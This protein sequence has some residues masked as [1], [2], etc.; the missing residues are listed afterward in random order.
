MIITPEFPQINIGQTDSLW[1][2]R[3]TSGPGPIADIDMTAT[4]LDSRVTYTGPPH[5]YF[6]Q[7]GQLFQSALNQYPLE[8]SN[9]A[10]IGRHQPEKASVNRITDRDFTGV[11]PAGG[12]GPW[13]VAGNPTPVVTPPGTLPA[14][15]IPYAKVTVINGWNIGG[16]FD[17]ETNAFIVGPTSNFKVNPI[18]INNMDINSRI[19]L[20]Y[21]KAA[22][23][24]IRY[25]NT[26]LNAT[27]YMYGLFGSIPAGNGV[28][29]QFFSQDATNRYSGLCQAEE[30]LIATSPFNGNRAQSTVLIDTQGAS[31]LTVFFSDGTTLPINAPSNPWIVPQ[32]TQDWGLKYIQKITF[33]R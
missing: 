24:S 20:S 16:I 7:N 22:P 1:F 19:S 5:A 6:G 31:S 10:A 9:G 13:I 25:Y 12:A 11:S 23:G 4:A 15:R 32:A 26:R 18:P 30:G 33:V 17:I 28:F 21:T 29:S 8:Y 27:N 14:G 3:R 2:G